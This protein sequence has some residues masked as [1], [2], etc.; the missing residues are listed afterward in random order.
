MNVEGIT[1]RFIDT[2]GLREAT[3]SIEAMEASVALSSSTSEKV[4]ENQATWMSQ[5]ESVSTRLAELS[6]KMDRLND[7]LESREGSSTQA[8]GE[9]DLSSL[10][11]RIHIKLGEQLTGQVSELVEQVNSR[12]TPGAHE[13]S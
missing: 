10:A 13:L 12:I 7:R 11:D 9:D 2:A 8:I 4:L 3:D 5:L 6:E 1:F